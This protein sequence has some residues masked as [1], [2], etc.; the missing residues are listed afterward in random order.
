MVMQWRT[1]TPGGLNRYYYS[2]EDEAYSEACRMADTFGTSRTIETI[3]R[4]DTLED[5]TEHD[6]WETVCTVHP[7]ERM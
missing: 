2:T 1:V 4:T 3:V 6:V 7:I 5:G